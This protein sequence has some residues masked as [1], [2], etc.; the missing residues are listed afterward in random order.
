MSITKFI[1]VS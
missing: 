1:T